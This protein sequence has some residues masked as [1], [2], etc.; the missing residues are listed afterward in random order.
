M[1]PQ[2]PTPQPTPKPIRW[3]C[4]LGLLMGMGLLGLLGVGGAY[5]WVSAALPE[6]TATPQPT[7]TAVAVVPTATR[8]ALVI[9]T[10]PP[11][12]TPAP[13]PTPTD[14]ATPTPSPTPTA[15]PTATATPIPTAT[16]TPTITPTPTPGSLAAAVIVAPI[17]T[18]VPLPPDNAALVAFLNQAN[19]LATAYPPALDALDGQLALLDADPLMLSYGDWTR[20][21]GNA[22]VTLRS[23][24]DRTRRLTAPDAYAASWSSAV[25]AADQLDAAL[26]QLETALGS[27]D[28]T[29]L[30]NF[31]TLY[32][33]ARR[34]VLTAL[35]GVPP[36]PT[37]VPPPTN[38][39]G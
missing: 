34:A 29:A 28:A 21:T 36:P 27:L 16:P 11:T 20:T 8:P 13:T 25:A 12:D 35:S 30:S 9:I 3:G 10:P 4:L 31:R 6:P 1:A 19:L 17:A 37:P 7:P 22:L 23:L 38:I 24:N 2:L 26:A 39:P 33:P 32:P 15:T 18:P 5:L 14:T